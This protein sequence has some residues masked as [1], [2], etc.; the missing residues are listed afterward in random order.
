MCFLA[1]QKRPL[2]RNHVLI[3]RGLMA[4]FI[5]ITSNSHLKNPMKIASLLLAAIV[6]AAGLS[7]CNSNKNTPPPMVDMGSRSYK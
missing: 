3:L 7:S 6:V 2:Y 4:V 5:I 1:L